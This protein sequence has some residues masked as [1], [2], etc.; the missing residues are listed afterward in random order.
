MFHNTDFQIKINNTTYG[1]KYF[2]D[3][4]ED[5]IKVSVDVTN[6]SSGET[7]SPRI[8]PY[9]CSQFSV[10]A[11]LALGM[12]VRNRFNW[13]S[14]ELFDL[15]GEANLNQKITPIDYAML[16]SLPGSPANKYRSI[17]I[18]QKA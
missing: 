4:E 3:V 9:H 16:I 8:S 10:S 1:V 18:K 7:F 11:W 14:E 17:H 6:L 5:C 2:E 13:F 12:P 15:L